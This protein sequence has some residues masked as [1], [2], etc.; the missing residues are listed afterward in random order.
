M[1]RIL[2][3][4]LIYCLTITSALAGLPPTTSKAIGD[5]ANKTTFNFQFPNSYVTHTGVTSVFGGGIST[6]VKNALTPNEG[7]QVYDTTLHAPSFYD[8]TNW[9]NGLG[10][11]TV[12]TDWA[13]CTFSSLADI[14]TG[15]YGLGTITNNS[16]MCRRQG[17]NLQMMGVFTLGTVSTNQARFPLPNNYGSITTAVTASVKDSYGAIIY[18]AAS[19]GTMFNAIATSGLSYFNISSA[20]VSNSNDPSAAV[21]GNTVFGTG[22]VLTLRGISIPVSGWSSNAAT[23]STANANYDWV[24]YTPS[25]LQGIGTTSPTTNQCQHMRIGGNL[26][27][28]CN[29]VT[30]TTGASQMQ[31][32]LP[33]GLTVSSTS[34]ANSLGGSWSSTNSGTYFGTVILQPSV[35]Y[36]N[37]GLS[38]TGTIGLTPQNGSSLMGNTTT[39]SMNAGPIPIAGWSNLSQVVATIVGVPQVPGI[40]AGTNLDTF[41]V[42]YGTTNATTAC[43]ANPCSYFDVIGTGATSM[44]WTSTGLMTLNLARTYSKLKCQVSASNGTVSLSGIKSQP[45]CASCSSLVLQTGDYNSIQNTYG[46]LM[47]QGSY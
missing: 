13:V 44:G 24:S 1:N 4:L 38:G 45:S 41:S 3:I 27:V 20:T 21:N 34:A 10:T 8:G 18:N 16:L 17:S 37:F 36:V 32:G 6:T 12:D 5:A 25:I 43:S 30:G 7:F 19:A 11:I 22:N 29:F 26:Y 15:F 9:Q 28:K 46:T 2:T 14:T 23:Y 39:F 35:S 40:T 42:S 47:C 31:I 33:S